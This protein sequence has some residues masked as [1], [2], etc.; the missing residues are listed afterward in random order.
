MQDNLPALDALALLADRDNGEAL[1]RVWS[2]AGLSD[3]GRERSAFLLAATVEVNPRAEELLQTVFA[4]SPADPRLCEAALAGIGMPD[5]ATNL[6]QSTN[7]PAPPHFRPD[8]VQRL[9][10]IESWRTVVADQQL[11]TLI[12]RV[13][14]RLAQHVAGEQ[15][16]Q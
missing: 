6:R 10:V 1:T 12:D 4:A 5:F 16:A 7:F 8:Y 2:T 9:R 3:A 13:H 15:R 11:L 14:A